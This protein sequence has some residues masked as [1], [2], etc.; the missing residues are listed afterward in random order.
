VLASHM[1][2]PKVCRGIGLI[3]DP[4]YVRSF[5]SLTAEITRILVLPRIVQL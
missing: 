5:C 4:S 3:F 1:M 2:E